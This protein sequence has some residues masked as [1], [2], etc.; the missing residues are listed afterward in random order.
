MSSTRPSPP[1]G[2][3][4][5]AVPRRTQFAWPHDLNTAVWIGIGCMVV[6]QGFA[7]L[8]ERSAARHRGVVS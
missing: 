1:S 2:A 4:V 6:G 7:Y 8:A 3:G 5:R